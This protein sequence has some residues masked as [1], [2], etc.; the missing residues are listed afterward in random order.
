MCQTLVADTSRVNPVGRAIQALV[1]K[2]G[3]A[4]ATPARDSNLATRAGV[5]QDFTGLDVAVQL[6]LHVAS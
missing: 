1:C 4:G 3:E 5:I 2:T 6:R